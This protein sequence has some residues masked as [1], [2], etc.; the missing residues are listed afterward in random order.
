MRLSVG[1]ISLL[2]LAGIL[3]PREAEAQAAGSNT[4]FTLQQIVSLLEGKWSGTEILEMVR[5][6]CIGFTV[7]SAAEAELRRAGADA[8][9]LTGLR[10]VC[11]SA[12]RG[13]PAPRPTPVVQ[14]TLSIVG[15]LPPE[16]SRIVNQLPPSNN[17][18]ITLTPARAATVIVTAP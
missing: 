5:E 13:R 7:T 9:L 11:N 17:R 4:P 12:N 2:A 10:S 8:A 1:A 3:A 6:D 18:T 16:W 14:G 15:E